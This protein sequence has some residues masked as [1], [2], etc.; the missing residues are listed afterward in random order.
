MGDALVFH[1]NDWGTIDGTKKTK[2]GK[3]LEGGKV[4]VLF[5]VYHFE[6]LH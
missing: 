2:G 1:L 6:E 3:D 5:W 4:R